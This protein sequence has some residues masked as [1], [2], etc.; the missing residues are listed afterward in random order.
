MT[1][2]LL[3]ISLVIMVLMT[4]M[5]TMFLAIAM[6]IVFICCLIPAGLVTLFYQPSSVDDYDYRIFFSTA[7]CLQL[8]YF[9]VIHL[10]C[11]LSNHD[12]RKELWFMM[13]CNG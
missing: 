12:I 10:L 5:I 13:T 2:M 3:L 4:I 1:S 7:H 11:C 6:L 8:L 9:S